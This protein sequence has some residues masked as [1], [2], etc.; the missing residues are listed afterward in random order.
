MTAKNANR[1]PGEKMAYTMALILLSCCLQDWSVLRSICG[2][3]V[4]GIISS[5]RSPLLSFSRLL[6]C[7]PSRKTALCS[8]DVSYC[9]TRYLFSVHLT[10]LNCMKLNRLLKTHWFPFFS[11]F[12]HLKHFALFPQQLNLLI[13]KNRKTFPVFSGPFLL[14]TGDFDQAAQTRD[15]GLVLHSDFSF[16]NTPSFS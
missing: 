15:Q 2:N 9:C 3:P 1:I 5:L 6:V 4:I 10:K 7:R 16:L 12:I 13:L 8:L 14:V 11:P